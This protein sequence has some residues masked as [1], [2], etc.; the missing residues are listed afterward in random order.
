[1]V[2][3]RLK[4]H[5]TGSLRVELSPQ[6]S[7]LAAQRADEVGADGALLPLHRPRRVPLAEREP[8]RRGD[9]AAAGRSSP[10]EGAGKA[11]DRGADEVD[12]LLAEVAEEDLVPEVL[13]D[14]A[15]LPDHER[16]DHREE[17]EHAQEPE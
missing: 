9:E 11:P 8:R 4:V 2:E 14:G 16:D 15:P 6:R 1:M 10:R 12:V 17:P 3:S 5:S 13:A 7:D